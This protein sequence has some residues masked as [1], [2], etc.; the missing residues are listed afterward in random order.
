MSKYLLLLILWPAGAD[1]ILCSLGPGGTAY[2]A[3]SDQRPTPDAMELAGKVNAGLGPMCR[4]NCPTMSLF[5]NT[6]APG[7]MLVVGSGGQ[8]KIVYKPEFFTSIYEMYGDSGV[9]AILAHEVGHAIDANGTA[10]W[11]KATWSA[12]LRAD[13]WTGCALAK[14]NINSREL[15][16]AFSALE[17]Y[18]SPSHPAWAVRLPVVQAGYM[19]CGGK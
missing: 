5:R 13:A 17:R 16:S 8:A 1:Q 10:R 11:I 18:P 12:E 3:Y 19:E 15:R 9:S 14:M 7:I 2:N 6:S 4:P